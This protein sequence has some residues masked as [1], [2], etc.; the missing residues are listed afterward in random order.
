MFEREKE[1]EEAEGGGGG[2]KT[3]IAEP[4]LQNPWPLIFLIFSHDKSF[5]VFKPQIS[6]S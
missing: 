6:E 5:Q 2:A 1:E 4:K 3:L